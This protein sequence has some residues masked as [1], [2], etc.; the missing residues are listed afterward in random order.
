MMIQELPQPD[1]YSEL[2]IILVQIYGILL[3]YLYSMKSYR[4]MNEMK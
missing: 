2:K 3:H 4:W 1:D